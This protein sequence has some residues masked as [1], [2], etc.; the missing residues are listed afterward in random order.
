MFEADPL[1]T[2][3]DSL[4]N[5]TGDEYFSESDS[6]KN[7]GKFYEARGRKIIL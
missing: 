3:E 2:K 1:S 6:A 4:S 7:T 5:F